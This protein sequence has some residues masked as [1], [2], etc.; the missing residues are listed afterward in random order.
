M[1]R[2]SRTDDPLVYLNLPIG[3]SAWRERWITSRNKR[4][5]GVWD[6]SLERET[7]TLPC[8]RRLSYFLDGSLL[9]RENM[10]HIFVFHA[11]FLSGNSFLMKHAPTGYVL[12]CVNRVGYFGSDAA[13]ESYSYESFAADM[14]QLAD[15]LHV[16]QFLV[17]GHSSGGPCALACAAHLPNRVQAVGILSG[18]PEYAHAQIPNKKRVNRCCLG[19]FLP[20]LLRRVIPCLPLSRGA[21]NGLINDY[22][23]ETA[24][25]SYQTETIKQPTIVFVGQEDRVLPLHVSRHVHERL[26]N[27]ELRVVPNIGHL[28]LLQDNVLQDFFDSLLCLTAQSQE[29]L[30]T[31]EAAIETEATRRAQ[32][33]EIV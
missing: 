27:V 10:P 20:F 2:F 11:M 1:V 5:K 15:R 28:G 18:D 8:G 23:L 17:A 32:S 4:V 29:A 13:Q 33:I 31:P 19:C 22:R 14:E 16:K 25:Y 9:H 21:R 24:N 30:E 3:V 6:A 12:V 7:L 26:E